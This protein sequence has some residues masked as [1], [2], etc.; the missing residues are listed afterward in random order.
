[1]RKTLTVASC[2]ITISIV[3]RLIFAILAI[4]TVLA[5]F[6]VLAVLAVFTVFT[7]STVV[8]SLLTILSVHIGSLPFGISI[9]FA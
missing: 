5:I 2:S 7:W 4:L 1:M 9:I 3:Q 8:E 6:A